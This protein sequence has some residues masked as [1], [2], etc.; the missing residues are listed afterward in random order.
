MRFFDNLL[1][2]IRYALRGFSS[3]PGVM[4]AAVVAIAVGIGI[5]TGL[6]TV[7]NGVLLR[8][9]LAPEAEQ[10]VSIHQILPDGGQRSVRGSRSM[11]SFSEY[12]TYRESARTLSGVFGLYLGTDQRDA[13][14]RRAARNSGQLGVVQLFRRVA[15][16]ARRR[17]QLHTR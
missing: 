5:N 1:G 6:F 16:G 4:V 9:L 14:R 7:L 8:E 17:A 12:E 10:L 13:R 2:D 3:S 11:F 15:R